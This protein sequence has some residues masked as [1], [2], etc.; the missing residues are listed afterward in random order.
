MIFQLLLVLF[1]ILIVVILYYSFKQDNKEI[2]YNSYIEEQEIVRGLNKTVM[3]S[4]YVSI[5]DNQGF[6]YVGD[7]PTNYSHWRI[8]LI[9]EDKVI[10]TIP[11]SLYKTSGVI[12]IILTNNQLIMKTIKERAMKRHS[13]YASDKQLFLI[14]K[15]MNYDKI[16]VKFTGYY[17]QNSKLGFQLERCV[18]DD[19]EHFEVEDVIKRR[20]LKIEGKNNENIL[21]NIKRST[22]EIQEVNID[23]RLVMENV[24][25]YLLE[26]TNEEGLNCISYRSSNIDLERDGIKLVREDYM[27]ELNKKNDDIPFYHEDDRLRV[28]FDI[29]HQ[30]DVVDSTHV[31]IYNSDNNELLNIFFIDKKYNKKDTVSSIKYSPPD[32]VKSVY[33]IHRM[34]DCPIN[35]CKPYQQNIVPF[36]VHKWRLIV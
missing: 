16:K 2:V 1:I 27:N 4:D 9:S 23:Q 12:G 21:N 11:S 31:E 35:H 19:I 30:M 10:D 18:F 14:E 5:L 13:E 24:D 36:V 29:P 8:D 15:G 17:Y 20:I 34:Y 26:E 32:N 22:K 6:Y 3:F 33:L 7:I 25:V 28:V